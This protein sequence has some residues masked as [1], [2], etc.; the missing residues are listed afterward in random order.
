MVDE[1]KV[2]E[3]YLDQEVEETDPDELIGKMLR[4]EVEG[5][6]RK[7]IRK[8]PD[9]Q[10]RLDALVTKAIERFFGKEV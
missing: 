1:Q 7:R 4:V 2:F 9:Y 6:L 3:D 5:E 8:H 10:K